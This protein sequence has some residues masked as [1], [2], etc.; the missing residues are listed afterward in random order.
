MENDVKFIL[1]SLANESF[2]SII[3]TK[4]F[5]GTTHAFNRQEAYAHITFLA[6]IAQNHLRYRDVIEET[7]LGLLLRAISIITEIFILASFL[8]ATSIDV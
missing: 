4:P 2:S 1:E 3:Q 5:W 7:V 6:E 8:Q